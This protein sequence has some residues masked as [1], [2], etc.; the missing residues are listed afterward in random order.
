VD[1]G[2]VIQGAALPDGGADTVFLG[3]SIE[4]ALASPASPGAFEVLQRLVDRFG[5]RAWIISKCGPR[6]EHKTRL[7]LDHHDFWRRTGISASNLRFCRERAE[8]ALHCAELGVTH[9][10]DDRLDVHRAIRDLVPYRYLFGP[11]ETPAPPW[12]T[13]VLTWID[14]EHRVLADLPPAHSVS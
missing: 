5:G 7:W 6:I 12:V 10:I 11:Q 9:M 3:G 14:V 4:Q 2:R 13:P 8:K 1:F